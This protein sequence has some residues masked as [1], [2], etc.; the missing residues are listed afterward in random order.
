M[1]EEIQESIP[2]DILKFLKSIKNLG[3]FLTQMNTMTIQ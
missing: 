3:K 1:I 2:E